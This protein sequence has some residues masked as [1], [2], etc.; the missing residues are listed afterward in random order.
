MKHTLV[1]RLF[2]TDEVW[3]ASH[4]RYAPAVGAVVPQCMDTFGG[5]RKGRIPAPV[6]R[7]ALD[8][9]SNDISELLTVRSLL[10]SALHVSCQAMHGKQLQNRNARY[11][12]AGLLLAMLVG[13]C[14]DDSGPP[15]GP[16]A[17]TVL[18]TGRAVVNISSDNQSCPDKTP[19][20]GNFGP[21]ATTGSVITVQGNDYVARPDGSRYGDFEIRLRPGTGTAAEVPV[22]G[23]MRGHAIDLLS[24]ISFPNPARVG[25]D[26]GVLTGTLFVQLSAL[27]GSMTGRI[28]YTDTQGGL[29]NCTAANWNLA[30]IR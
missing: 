13:A 9:P 20:W 27:I 1:Q 2:D 18:P 19:I 22:T 4:S 7:R 17:P 11:A 28:S 10:G 24:V 26:D 14:G 16:S 23:T 6:D 25:T 12:L 29:T 3:R 21:R 30:A 5:L 8:V 15:T